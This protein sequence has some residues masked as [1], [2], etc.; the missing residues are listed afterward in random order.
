MS[1][2]WG[3]LV[4][5]TKGC[6]VNVSSDT[7]FLLTN[8]AVQQNGETQLS[9]RVVLLASVNGGPSFA[10]VSFIIGYFE[11]TQLNLMFAPDD[12]VRFSI[13]GIPATIC[14]CGYVNHL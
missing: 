2:F 13:E 5:P 11:S 7:H 10:I 4:E 1:S 14:I 9:G 6:N 8:A 12:C 3:S